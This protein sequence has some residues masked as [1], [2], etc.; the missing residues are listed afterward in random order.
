MR[1]IKEDRKCDM[2]GNVLYMDTGI[3]VGSEVKITSRWVGMFSV[4]FHQDDFDLCMK[5]TNEIMVRCK[6]PQLSGDT[7]S[8]S[9]QRKLGFLK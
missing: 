3:F 2:C 1:T 9:E 4:S 8:E 6:R 5:C 7:L